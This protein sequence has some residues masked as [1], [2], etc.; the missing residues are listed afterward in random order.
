M[1]AMQKINP[2]SIPVFITARMGS[3]RF[4]GKHLKEICGKPVIE[5]MISRIKQ[6]KLPSSI[7]LCTTYLSE[8]D[9]FEDIANRCNINIFRGHPTD[10]L[11]RWLATSDF[12]KCQLFSV[13]K[14]TMYFVILSL[15]ISS[16]K[17]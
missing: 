10:I 17:I 12:L 11:K 13:Q 4:P 2:N 15:S 16:L 6:A 14:P 1:T 9:V 7:V 8:D 3:T 5:Q